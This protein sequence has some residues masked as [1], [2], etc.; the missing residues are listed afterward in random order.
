MT[1]QSVQVAA[2]GPVGIGGW[3]ILP[4]IGLI[5]SCLLTGYSLLQSLPDIEALMAATDL[6]EGLYTFVLI[7][8]AANVALIVLALGTL[9]RLF[10]KS[11]RFPATYI[12]WLVFSLVVVVGDTLVA[13]L[14][15]DIASDDQSIKDI[16]RTVAACAI[17]IPYTLVSVRVKNTFV[18]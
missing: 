5:G 14:V 18:H 16:V 4:I 7:E 11:R 6:P 12:S 10:A 9:A 15:F 1:Q 17:W 3:L 2:E 8:L 13:T